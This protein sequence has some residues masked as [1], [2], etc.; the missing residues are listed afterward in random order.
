MF[1]PDAF[2]TLEEGFEGAEQFD[3]P[4]NS[5][6]RQGTLPNV[7]RSSPYDEPMISNQI[8]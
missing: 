8:Q 6:W 5:C 4:E 3:S 2:F 7:D 1:T